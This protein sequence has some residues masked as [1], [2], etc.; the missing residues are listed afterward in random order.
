MHGCVLFFVQDTRARKEGCH[1][2]SF[3]FAP[4]P[5]HDPTL[6]LL[7]VLTNKAALGFSRRHVAAPVVVALRRAPT[8][9]RVAGATDSVPPSGPCALRA[10]S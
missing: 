9:S 2:V 4:T 10:T 6:Y 7:A 8:T 3:T 5:T 1:Q